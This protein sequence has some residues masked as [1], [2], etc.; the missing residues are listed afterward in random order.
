MDISC[1]QAL[2]I[3]FWRKR[4]E[5]VL[6]SVEYI[7]RRPSRGNEKKE[8]WMSIKKNDDR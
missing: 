2:P 7:E 3:W 5:S 8:E 4:G 1:C 6:T